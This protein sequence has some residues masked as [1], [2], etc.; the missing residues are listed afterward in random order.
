MERGSGF[1]QQLAEPLEVECVVAVACV[2]GTA[3]RGDELRRPELAQVVGDERLRLADR[4]RQ[5]AH[6]AV[7]QRELAEE[8]PAERM[9]GEAKEHRRS[10]HGVRRYIK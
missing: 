2:E 5:L 1:R 3:S 4:R 8:P 6:A 10:I 9:A 7:A